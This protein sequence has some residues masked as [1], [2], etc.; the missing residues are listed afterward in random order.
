MTHRNRP[1]GASAAAGAIATAVA[2]LALLTACASTPPTP[3][4][5][6]AAA[7][8]PAASAAPLD[9]ILDP[10]YGPLVEAKAG[11]YRF[12]IPAAYFR[13]Q[14][15]PYFD[16]SWGVELLWP[17]LGPVPLGG[18]R[19]LDVR[20]QARVVS[21]DYSYIDR[22][23]INSLIERYVTPNGDSAEQLEDP[24]QSLHLRSRHGPVHGLWRYSV[25]Y[26]THKRHIDKF[27]GGHPAM[28]EPRNRNDWYVA[29]RPDGRLRTL[30][31]CDSLEFPEQYVIEGERLRHLG[32][33]PIP[34][35]VHYFTLPERKV[36]VMLDY[37]RVFLKDWAL[38]ERRAVELLDAFLVND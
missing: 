15:G 25:D 30:I 37:N 9:P 5:P 3:A 33:V 28:L 17:R 31:D 2:A 23:D 18:R 21:V 20:G 26:A 6:G 19:D 4:A 35:C 8:Q 36:R 29:Y 38:F 12:R 13:T 1:P 32:G 22:V 10:A 24:T 16:G 11:P 7:A 34:G 14:L 27:H